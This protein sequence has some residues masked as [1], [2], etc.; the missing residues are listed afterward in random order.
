MVFDWG[1]Y[2]VLAEELGVRR[3]DEAALRSAVSRAYYAAFCKARHH[4]DQEG[5][6]I[7]RTGTAHTLV[8]NKY[9]QGAERHRRFIGTTRDRLRRH[10]NKADYDNEVSRLV[11]VVLNTLTR[12]RQLLESLGSLGRWRVLKGM[13]MNSMERGY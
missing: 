7:P 6:G 12:A 4:L 3:D 8:W 13:G 9:R 1:R 2:L 5:V 10:R 11:T